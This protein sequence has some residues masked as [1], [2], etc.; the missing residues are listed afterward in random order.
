[1][2]QIAMTKKYLFLLFIALLGLKDLTA[3]NDFKTYF[4]PHLNIKL[5]RENH[6][7]FSFGIA[8]RD[9]IYANENFIFEGKHLEISHFTRYKIGKKAKAGA[10]VLYRFIDIFN[11]LSHDELRFT[12]EFRSIL[13][14]DNFRID[15]RFRVEERLFLHTTFRIRYRISGNLPLEREEKSKEPWSLR[16]ATESLLSTGKYEIPSYD[17]RLR[18]GIRKEFETNYR[19]SFG[20]EYR[21][22][23]YTNDP[24][25]ELYILT[26]LSLAI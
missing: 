25:G 16:M 9:L 18:I 26:G 15:Q 22:Q 2:N 13:K 23:H 24:D 12:Q 14:E 4:E 6:W 11:H 7:D 3:Q 21:L 8:N 5:D 20:I 1:M 19:A 10:G 17:Q